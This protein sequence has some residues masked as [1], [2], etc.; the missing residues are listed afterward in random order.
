MKIKKTET[1]KSLH[2]QLDMIPQIWSRQ[3]RVETMT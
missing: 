2:G 1:Q 3:R